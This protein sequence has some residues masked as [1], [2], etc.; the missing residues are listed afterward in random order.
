MKLLRCNFSNLTKE[1]T[2]DKI[3]KSI[4][5][6]KK[7]VYMDINADK[8]VTI[9][10]DPTMQKYVDE[11]DIV[12]PDG[13]A[14]FWASKFLG[15]PLKERIAGVDLFVELIKV[16]A[17]KGYRIYFLGAKQEVIEL[18]I[19][20][21]RREYGDSVIGGYRNGYFSEEDEENI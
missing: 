13:M 3:V 18:M 16:S 17:E 12:N 10:K 5:Q 11:A 15:K 19:E 21:I 9:Y 1:E 14:V 20:K 6:N 2:I 8:I 4:D 7:I